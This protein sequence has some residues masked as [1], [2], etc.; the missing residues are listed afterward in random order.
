MAE[1]HQDFGLAF[2][3]K[4]IVILKM[5]VV[6]PDQVIT[7]VR[8]TYFFKV[9]DHHSKP[10]NPRGVELLVYHPHQGSWKSVTV[11]LSGKNR[12]CT[13][14]AT[15]TISVTSRCVKYVFPGTKCT[16]W[17]YACLQKKF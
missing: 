15:G 17:P 4:I 8:A 11:Y 6:F 3:K 5:F 7:T 9:D 16:L 10:M 14:S 2:L 13:L 12:L 1:S